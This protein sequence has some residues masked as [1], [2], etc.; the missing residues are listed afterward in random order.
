MRTKA[1]AE[2]K[3]SGLKKYNTGKPCI[4]GHM[5]DRYTGTGHCV[6]CDISRSSKFARENRVA[7]SKYHKEWRHKNAE[8]QRKKLSERRRRPG[9]LA[10]HNAVNAQWRRDNPDYMDKWRENNREAYIAHKKVSAH[11]RRARKLSAEGS[12]ATSDIRAIYKAQRGKC[13]YC[14][15]PLKNKYQIDHI[16]PLSRGGNNFPSN[17]Q[18]LCEN[19]RGAKSCNQMKSAKDPIDFANSIGLLL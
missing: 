2:A 4:H 3:A 8:S 10:K 12:H 19:V 5:A 7:I 18:L 14:K 15:K 9:V 16:M 17:L 6:E 1:R 11:R 13:A